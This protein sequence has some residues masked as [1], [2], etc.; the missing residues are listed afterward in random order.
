[1]KKIIDGIKILRP[2]DKYGKYT[3]E[4]MLTGAV[5]TIERTAQAEGEYKVF[6]KD[7]F[8]NI[9]LNNKSLKIKIN[10]DQIIQFREY[11]NRVH[12]SNNM[13]ITALPMKDIREI[14]NRTFYIDG[15]RDVVDFER[16]T[17]MD[18][19]SIECLFLY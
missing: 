7:S 4:N 9:M 5:F 12:L 3:V 14:A 13:S 17:I 15:Q 11:R 8:D 2:K 6:Y 18:Y 16:L 1:M 10:K 19:N